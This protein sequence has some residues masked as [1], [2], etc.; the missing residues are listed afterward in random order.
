[1]TNYSKPRAAVFYSLLFIGFLIT[2]ECALRIL[3]FCFLRPSSP[4]KTMHAGA[5]NIV[6][7]GDSFTYGLEVPRAATYPKQLEQR[8]DQGQ[9]K[10]RVKV[11][12]LGIPGTNSS[13]HLKMFEDIAGKSQH[14][15][16]VIILTGANDPWNFARS[17]INMFLDHQSFL[18]RAKVDLSIFLCDLRIYK[19]MKIIVLN[20]QGGSGDPE[21]D[22]F[23]QILKKEKLDTNVLRHLLEYNLT[24][25]IK[26]AQMN[27]IRIILLNYPRGG[28][29][30][31]D[32]EPTLSS[33]YGVPFVDIH[34]LFTENLKTHAIPDLF[35]HDF[36]HPNA[37]GNTLIANALYQTIVARDILHPRQ[38]IY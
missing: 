17:N 31:G 11:Y 13:Q 6:C 10:T 16:L 9:G 30:G 12:D 29:Y 36:S 3:G 33:R 19:M 14:I 37:K 26:M 34:Q 18:E 22:P 8:F 23:Q 28:L 38:A 24:G 15:N 7:I 27:N 32:I 21:T 2:V 4:E 1:M 25:M 35:L 5:Y 20:I